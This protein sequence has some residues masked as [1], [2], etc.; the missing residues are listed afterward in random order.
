MVIPTYAIH[1]DPELYPQ[2]ERF[3]PERFSDEQKSG[4]HPFAYLPFGEGPRICI[5]LRFGQLQAKIGLASLLRRFRFEV[6]ERTEVPI[7]VD[8]INLLYVPLN[9]VWLRVV[10][11]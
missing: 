5:G 6:C 10:R 1:H 3:D 9:G 4:R 2:P 11:V 7:K 8:Q